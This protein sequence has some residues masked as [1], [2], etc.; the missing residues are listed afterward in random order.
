MTLLYG[1]TILL[2]D[3]ELSSYKIRN[4]STIDLC[5]TNFSTKDKAWE[6]ILYVIP[7]TGRNFVIN[8]ASAHTILQIKHLID[9][10]IGITE[11]Q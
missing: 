5:V 10:A 6:G 11:E 4:N 1:N 2:N 8:A 3:Q 9:Q 7:V